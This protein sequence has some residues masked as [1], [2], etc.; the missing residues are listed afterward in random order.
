MDLPRA[1]F[2]A[3]RDRRFGTGNPER[4]RLEFWEWMVLGHEGRPPGH[5]LAAPP[6]VPRPRWASAPGVRRHFDVG[7]ESSRDRPVW[8]FDR[9]GATR[10]RLPDGR[11]VCIGGEYEDYYDPDFCI[12]NDVV[13]LEP[14]G[15]VAIYGYPRD[16]FPPTDYHTSTVMGDRL[17]VIGG[18]GYQG[19]RRPGATPVFILH[20]DDYRI[21]PLETR[22]E[23]PGWIFEHSAR[24]EGESIV[25]SGGEVYLKEAGEEDSRRSFEEYALEVSTGTWRRTTDRG[26]RQ[27]RLILEDVDNLIV[28]EPDDPGPARVD[29]GDAYLDRSSLLPPGG[30]GASEIQ[31]D[32][33][34]R[35]V[36]ALVEGVPVAVEL[37]RGLE[38]ISLVIEGRM[39]EAKAAALAEGLGARVAKAC[40]RRCV[41][42]G[43]R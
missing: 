13:V 42:R 27:F 25:V 24:V 16:V 4:M 36:R 15:S 5:D 12:Y 35:G 8:T 33:A 14:D 21:E 11:V 38:A 40:G 30:E 7:Y 19:E 41:V 26:W 43:R 18:L 1:I 22:G 28:L 32:G 17:V 34:W 39:D 6:L 23:P 20:L 37:D 29:S 3:Q 2:D 31:D 10:D 9:W